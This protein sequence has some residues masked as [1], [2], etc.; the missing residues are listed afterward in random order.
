MTQTEIPGAED[1]NRNPE[2]DELVSTWLNAKDEARRT[3]Q[4]RKDA[5]H[6]LLAGCLRMGITRYPY[7]EDGKRKVF[8]PDTTARAKS[9]TVSS[10]KK[11]RKRRERDESPPEDREVESR[12]VPRSKAHDRAADPFAATRGGLLAAAEAAQDDKAAKP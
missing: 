1:P 3:A 2:L 10:G 12:R 8:T 6:A 4:K 9:I 11:P 7:Q 5:E